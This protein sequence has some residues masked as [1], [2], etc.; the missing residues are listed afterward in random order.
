M[1]NQLTLRD[2]V[3]LINAK[4]YPTYDSKN[5]I[6]TITGAYYI[7]NNTIRNNRIRVTDSKDKVGKPCQMTGWINT[8]DIVEKVEAD[9][10]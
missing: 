3:R 10:E 2:E 7:Y 5:S 4:L 9:E 8:S 1:M 6:K